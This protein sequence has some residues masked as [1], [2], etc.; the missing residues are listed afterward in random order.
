MKHYR[1]KPRVKNILAVILLYTELV[2]VT[3][4]ISK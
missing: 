2:I 4:I 1:L 3:L